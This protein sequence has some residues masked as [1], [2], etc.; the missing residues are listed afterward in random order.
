MSYNIL[1]AGT[2]GTGKT[3]LF[4]L[5]TGKKPDEEQLSGAVH[6]GG[7]A[8]LLNEFNPVENL[9]EIIDT[10]GVNSLLDENPDG[11]KL[12]D[13]LLNT[14]VSHIIVMADGRYFR[15]TLALLI[16]FLIL[17]KPVSLVF[18]EYGNGDDFT[19]IE[20]G[21]LE[22][23]IP[24]QKFPEIDSVKTFINNIIGSDNHAISDIIFENNKEIGWIHEFSPENECR[25]LFCITDLLPPEKCSV[26]PSEYAELRTKIEDSGYFQRADLNIVDHS[27][28][29]SDTLRKTDKDETIVPDVSKLG[30]WLQRPLTGIPVAI[31]IFFLMYLFVGHFGAGIVVDFIDK[32]VF[33]AYLIPFFNSIVSYIPWNIVQR[34]LMDPDFGLVP[35]GIFLAVG[36]VMPV[37][38]LF[39]LFIGF[40]EESGYF[41]RLSVLFDRLMRPIGLNGKGIFPIIMG[42]SCITMALATTRMLESKKERIIASFLLMLAIPCAPL[43]GAMFL[44]LGNLHFTAFIFVISVIFLQMTFAGYIA[45]KVIKGKLPEFII[46][47]RP[48]KLPGFMLLL[49]R[50]TLRTWYFMKEA[51]PVFIIASAVLFLLAEIGV[52]LWLQNA[53]QGVVTDFWGLPPETVQV[54]LKTIIRRENGIAELARIKQL[55]TPVQLITT[56]LIMSFLVPCV[57]S[58]IMLIKERGIKT[59][60][61]IITVVLTYSTLLG[62]ILNWFFRLVPL[63]R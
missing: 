13:I 32:K 9:I 40:L 57:N 5:L 6:D 61:I 37:L 50:T 10:P 18:N 3:E 35:T 19:E 15:R 47:L 56:V 16:Q 20:N 46:E 14:D 2:S 60:M 55:F 1:I 53:S 51:L 38:F 29:C 30:L 7:H 8:T 17:Q 43:M 54:L 22:G 25:T 41:P 26:I 49:K 31:G 34:L 24:Y 21:C 12:R 45:N 44:I 42:F 59:S 36:I 4:R 33:S 28:T 39:Y 27:F 63:Y 62:G 48:L 23:G 11:Y 52:L 58:I